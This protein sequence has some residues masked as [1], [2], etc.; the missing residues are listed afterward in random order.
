MDLTFDGGRGFQFISVLVSFFVVN[1][2]GNAISRLWEARGLLGTMLHA[3]EMLALRAAVY[4]SRETGANADM[5]RGQ[6]KDLLVELVETSMTLIQNEN[7]AVL[8]SLLA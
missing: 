7:A 1:N 4:S 5:W 8:F 2:I 3:A 6:V